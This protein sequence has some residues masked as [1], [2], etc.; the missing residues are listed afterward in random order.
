MEMYRQI[1][2]E[3]REK[4]FTLYDEDFDELMATSGFVEQT[5]AGLTEQ[6]YRMNGMAMRW[7]YHIIYLPQMQLVW[8]TQQL[9]F[10][11]VMPCRIGEEMVQMHFGLTGY[12][13]SPLDGHHMH[14]QANQH[15]L[16]YL[17]GNLDDRV[18]SARCADYRTFE[19]NIEP[20]FL[21]RILPHHPDLIPGFSSGLVQGAS[22]LLGQQAR[23]ITPAM[24]Q[25]IYDMKHC[26]L[27]SLLRQTYLEPK[28]KELLALQ[29]AQFIDQP[30]ASQKIHSADRDK[31][32]ALKEWIAIH[33]SEPLTLRQLA[34]LSGL[35]T[36]KVVKG[37]KHLFGTTL[38]AYITNLRLEQARELILAGGLPIS[39]I[40]LQAGYKNPQH[41]ST[42]FKRKFGYLPSLL[43][44]MNQE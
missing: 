32:H 4:R 5:E 24:L 26:L 37:F 39:Q 12:Q 42:A 30:V 23:P 9:P 28:V 38:F 15:N 10:D 6:A 33:Y 1:K 2:K 35:N 8:S 18:D 25:V 40:S 27:P 29:I 17:R 36:D 14:V 43:R 11:L 7:H 34:T 22:R 44:Q 13:Y 41:F 21:D 16:F 31:L 19:I 20:T 3:C